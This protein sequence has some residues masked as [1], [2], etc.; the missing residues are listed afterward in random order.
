[1]N[2]APPSMALTA[3]PMMNHWLLYKPIAASA[4]TGPGNEF[5]HGSLLSPVASQAG[6]FGTA[7]MQTDAIYFLSANK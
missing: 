5:Q 7:R 3:M 1:M 4:Q 2:A 6:Q